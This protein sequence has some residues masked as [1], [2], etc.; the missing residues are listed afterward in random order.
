[1]ILGLIKRN[2]AHV[3][4]EL[5]VLLYKSLVRSHLEFSY[6]VWSP[7]KVGLIEIRGVNEPERTGTAFRLE[8]VQPERRSCSSVTVFENAVPPAEQKMA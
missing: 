4:K 7:Y 6:S 5:F 8:F 1:M 3:G 2:F